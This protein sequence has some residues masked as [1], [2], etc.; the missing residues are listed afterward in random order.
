VATSMRLLRT[1]TTKRPVY[2]LVVIDKSRANKGGII[3]NLGMVDVSAKETK[4]AVKEDR[5]L[6]WLKQGAEPTDTVKGLLKGA[7]IWAKW[8]VNKADSA[9]VT[10][11]A[12]KARPAKA[13]KATKVAPAAKAKK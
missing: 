4:H 11:A 2:R 6:A 12:A 10:K 9:A 7:G 13:P 1:G 5:T 3:E 8:T